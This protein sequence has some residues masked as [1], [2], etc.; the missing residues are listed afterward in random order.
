M[1]RRI[2]TQAS[3]DALIAA[4]TTEVVLAPGDIVTALAREYAQDRGVRLIP[5]A[6]GAAPA[7]SVIPVTSTRATIRA[8]VVKALGY[9]PDG[10]DAVID[11]AMP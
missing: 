11:R 3:I 8:E 5:P 4:G 1:P 6:G 9:E 10:L 2:L 7:A